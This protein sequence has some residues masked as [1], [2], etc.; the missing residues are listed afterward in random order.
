MEVFKTPGHPKNLCGFF[1]E[2]STGITA[3]IP[4]NAN[5]TVLQQQKILSKQNLISDSIAAMVIRKTFVYLKN[6]GN[7]DQLEK[8]GRSVISK[9]PVSMNHKVIANVMTM[10]RFAITENGTKCFNLRI[11]PIMMHGMTVTAM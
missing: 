7:C 3:L 5:I 6:S 11:S 1:M 10:Q 9:G 2:F 4:S 8:R